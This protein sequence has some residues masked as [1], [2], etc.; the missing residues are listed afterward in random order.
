MIEEIKEV[1]EEM[2]VAY[3]ELSNHSQIN[4]DY[5]DFAR[6]AV[7]QFRTALGNPDLTREALE[8]MLR[9]GLSKYKSVCPNP[10]YCAIEP[11]WTNFVASHMAKASNT[12]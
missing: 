3:N 7:G 9:D 11:S 10:E 1:I 4:A 12:R 8:K 2:D 5:P 6:M